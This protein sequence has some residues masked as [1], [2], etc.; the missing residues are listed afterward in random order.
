MLETVFGQFYIAVVV[1]RLVGIRLTQGV[2]RSR[3]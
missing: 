3:E 2:Q 1:A